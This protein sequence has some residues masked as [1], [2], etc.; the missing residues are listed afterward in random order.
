MAI[1]IPWDEHEAAIL[2]DAC[3]AVIDVKISRTE[4]VL[5]VSKTLREKAIKNGIKI[6][7]I[8]RNEN[9][10][11]MQMS[12]MMALIL[13]IPSGLHKT[14]KVFIDI[15]HLYKNNLDQFQKVLEKAKKGETVMSENKSIFYRWLNNSV[16][17]SDVSYIKKACN[18]VDTYSKNNVKLGYSL[19]EANQLVD[20]HK[21]IKVI[22]KD[23]F[24]RAKNERQIQKIE[25]ALNEY[26][27]FMKECL[28][29]NKETFISNKNQTDNI[30]VCSNETITSEKT[31]NS[32][33]KFLNVD[34]ERYKEILSKN[35]KK[36]FRLNDKLSLRRFRMQW[37]STFKDELQY[38]DKTICEHISHLT[39][40]HGDMA[41]LPEDMLNN[42]AKC[43]LLAYITDLF[44]KGKTVIYYEALC[45]EFADDFAIGRINNAEMLK[46]YL[47]YINNGSMYLCKNYITS[48]SNVEVNNLEEVRSF[49]IG[50]GMP[51]KTEN[52]IFSLSHIAKNEIRRVIA[53]SEFIQNR[54]GEY[55]HA[56]IIEFTQHE[57]DLITKWIDIAINDKEYM[58]G[59][60]LTDTIQNKLPSI[61]E[62]YP[63]LTEL[64][65]RDVLAYKLKNLFS[66]HGKI[67]SSY[68]KNL[69][70]TDV[71][72]HFAKT[73]EHFTLAQLCMLKND[74]D[75]SIYFDAVYANSLRINKNDFVSKNQARF[76]IDA[77]DTAIGQFFYSDYISIK[78]ISLFGGFPDAYFPW[79]HFLLQHY[80][81]NYSKKYK[82]I[83]AG[84][85]AEKP[86]GAIV[87]RNSQLDTFNDVI[88]KILAESKIPL[89]SD[90]V[91]QYLFDAGYIARRSI[92]SLDTIIIKANMY[93]T[94]KG[95]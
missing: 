20:I 81:A 68:G 23:V 91:L 84:F 46:T 19:F 57:I 52:I 60:E 69:S 25:K 70:M 83:H 44:S 92:S 85:N 45:R 67:I 21:I 29:D 11:S 62:R 71:F 16:R 56:D 38:D 34:F 86:V 90:D 63:Y 54:K 78:D 13:E 9:G 1:R 65:L 74:L 64:G 37:Q 2:L 79:N 66:F 72:A 73:H 22:K 32:K 95:E 28:Y 40:Q 31:T 30:Y 17:P 77:T 93:R 35:Y 82:L 12:I 18:L 7:S 36:G 8:Y 88:I 59:K 4:A 87:K 41:Y 3:L 27:R 58:G 6:D 24:F 33:E 89:N 49:L 80:I 55:F 50:Q 61:M 39:I 94:N 51:I 15:V 48:D 43:K 5:K 76:D 26:K 53:G 47:S 10:I 75:T 42:N 14:S